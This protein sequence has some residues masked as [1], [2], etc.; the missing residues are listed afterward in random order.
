MFSKTANSTTSTLSPL[1][2]SHSEELCVLQIN[3]AA[4]FT[5]NNLFFLSQQIDFQRLFVL[6][7]KKD[8]V[9]NALGN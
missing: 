2:P 1:S 4:L 5:V 7:H 9:S 3:A 6:F 8:T